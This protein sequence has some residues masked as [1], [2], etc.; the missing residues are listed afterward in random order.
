[1]ST[2]K[3]PAGGEQNKEGETEYA[4]TTT[5]K[6]P[7]P[8]GASIEFEA[9]SQTGNWSIGVGDLPPF[10]KDGFIEHKDSK[11]WRKSI[12]TPFWG[13]VAE[14]GAQVGMEFK[15][16]EVALKGVKV[17]YNARDDLY[18]IEAEVGTGLSLEVFFALTAGVAANPPGAADS[19][20]VSSAA[21][22][23]DCSVDDSSSPASGANQRRGASASEE[24]DR[25]DAAS[26]ESALS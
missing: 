20:A 9:P 13:L 11:W 10:N 6:I 3:C 5:V 7:I 25:G 12:P 21:I 15:L 2:E 17:A 18:A 1:M 22:S 19:A 8:G 24:A 23:L 26:T 4:S 16:G 14:V